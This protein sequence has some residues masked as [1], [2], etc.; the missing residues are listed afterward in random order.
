MTQP[1]RSTCVTRLPRYYEL[2]R[3]CVPRR[4]APSCDMTHLTFSLVISTT[5]SHVPTKSLDQRHAISTPDTAQPRYRSPLN[6]SQATKQDLVL[7]SF[8]LLSMRR[9][10]FTCVR[11]TGPYVTFL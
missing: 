1:L 3:P 7:M 6:C 5:G 8:D 2:L 10:W 11:L 4:Y 9:Q